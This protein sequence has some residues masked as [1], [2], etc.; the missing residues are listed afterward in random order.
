MSTAA[1]LPTK[2]SP[3]SSTRAGAL[4]LHLL[5]IFGELRHPPVVVLLGLLHRRRAGAL[6]GWAQ[7]RFEHSPPA[8]VELPPLQR[9]EERPTFRHEPAVDQRSPQLLGVGPLRDAQEVVNAGL[10]DRVVTRVVADGRRATPR[11]LLEQRGRLDSRL[12]AAR[13]GV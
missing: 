11:Q 12:V 6:A 9:A 5:E 3:T 4:L 7:M 2:S 8:V 1:T 13:G 10:D